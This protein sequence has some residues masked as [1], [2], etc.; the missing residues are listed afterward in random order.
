MNLV[1]FARVAMCTAAM[2]LGTS[3]TAFAQ[4]TAGSAFTYQGELRNAGVPVNGNADFRFRLYDAP[5]GGTQIG[6]TLSLT[7]QPVSGGRFTTELDFGAPAFAGQ[8]RYLEIDVRNPTGIGSFVTLAGRTSLTPT[9]YALFAL[10]GSTPGPAGPVGP[11]GPVGPA[12]PEG[13]SGVL[14]AFG[15]GGFANT[16]APAAST[17][18]FFGPL[19]TI[20]VPANG[21][22]LVSG[23]AGLGTTNAG[24]TTIEIDIGVRLSTTATAPSATSNF[25]VYLP[26]TNTRTAMSAH[27][28]IGP[29]AAGTY[30]VGMVYRNNIVAYNNNDWGQITALVLP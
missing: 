13:P 29:L 10:N 14:S 16:L 6:S 3:G 22:I 15:A 2:A 30:Q 28:L 18:T 24:N 27:R 25:I 9:P 4:S 1:R 12:G 17:W 23:T 11:E 19:L 5:A 20:T 26:A 21:R 8:A 7:N